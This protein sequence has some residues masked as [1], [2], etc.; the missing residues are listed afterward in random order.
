MREQEVNPALV[1]KYAIYPWRFVLAIEAVHIPSLKQ[2]PQT[3]FGASPA[4]EVER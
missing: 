2:Q 1:Q 3:V 4:A